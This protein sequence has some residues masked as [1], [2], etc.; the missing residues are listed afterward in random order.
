MARETLRSEVGGDASRSSALPDTF[1]VP[2]DRQPD[3]LN[4]P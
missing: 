4:K 1:E 2:P 3:E